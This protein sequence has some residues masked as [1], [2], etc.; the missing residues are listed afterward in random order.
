M[1]GLLQMLR[2]ALIR[3]AVIPAAVS[4]L[5]FLHDSGA[6]AVKR[7]HA[8]RISFRGSL[9]DVRMYIIRF[10]FQRNGP[11]EVAVWNQVDEP[12]V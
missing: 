9:R 5:H 10:N 8:R 2:S 12:I 11:N 3:P 6:C 4:H 1:N 7:D